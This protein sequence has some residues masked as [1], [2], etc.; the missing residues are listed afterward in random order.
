VSKPLVFEA[1]TAQGSRV[2]V[3][4]DAADPETVLVFT[5]TGDYG[6]WSR[7][8]ECRQVTP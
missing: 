2:R 5:L 3:V 8:L 1:E 6:T 4:W 7:P